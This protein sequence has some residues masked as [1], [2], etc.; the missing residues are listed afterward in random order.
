MKF[1]VRKNGEILAD[2]RLSFLIILLPGTESL[3]TKLELQFLAH[4]IENKK[5][6]FY[7]Y[8]VNTSNG[9]LNALRKNIDTIGNIKKQN[10]LTKNKK[11]FI[12][13]L[14]L[15]PDNFSQIEIEA[16]VAKYDWKKDI[17]FL[18]SL[19]FREEIVPFILQALDKRCE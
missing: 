2:P 3:S 15:L 13:P 10:R 11:V 4:T 9:D 5:N 12:W 7:V 1:G 6:Y 8:I 19:Y 16:L 17:V 14:A 18:P